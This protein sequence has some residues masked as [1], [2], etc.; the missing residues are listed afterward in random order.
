MRRL[1]FTFSI[2]GLALAAFPASATITYTSCTSG[3]SSTSGSYGTLPTEPGATGLAFSSPI[4][5]IAAG[6]NATTGIYTDTG[7]GT[8]GTGT[9]FTAYNG[10]NVDTGTQLYL[11]TFVQGN[12]GSNTGFQIQLPPNTY[13]FAMILTGYNNF[14][15]AAAGPG[16][17]SSCACPYPITIPSSGTA[18]FFGIVSDTALTSLFVSSLYSFNG[19]LEI[20]SFEIGQ[21]WASPTPEAGTFFTLGGGL[22]GLYFLRRPISF[23]LRTL[24]GA[25][26]LLG[27]QALP[28]PQMPVASA[29]RP[30]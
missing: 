8:G 22:L 15:D 7:A 25:R 5:F 3:C 27:P 9:V 10:S 6:L 12:N 11:T 23:R 21:E 24:S 2:L 19:R 18:E 26:T 17:Y 20:N 13:A 29:V 4:T 16:T 28:R 14:A 1:R 30:T